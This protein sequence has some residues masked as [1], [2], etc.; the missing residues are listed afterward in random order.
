[1]SKP[2]TPVHPFTYQPSSSRKHGP[3]GYTEYSRYKPWLRDEFTFRCAYCLMR[4][5]WQRDL[6]GFELDH[7]Q[8]V[9]TRPDLIVEYAN[10]VYACRGCNQKK[11]AYYIPEPSSVALRVEIN[12]LIVA[13]NDDGQRIIDLLS[14][15]DEKS[16]TFRRDMIQ[17]VRSLGSSDDPEA[18]KSYYSWVG[19]PAELPDLKKLHPPTNSRV[20]A[21][22]NSWHSLKE[23]GA[24][25][26]CYA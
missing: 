21:I 13:L 19:F 10:L 20:G 14:L 9:A 5:K 17:I 15:D 18:H 1:M 3:G 25:P 26:Q 6:N 11:N 7:F 16:T 2:I 12:G 4:E 23:R 22:E 8:P 24:L